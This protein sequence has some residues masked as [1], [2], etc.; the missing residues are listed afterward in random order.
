[1]TSI[2]RPNAPSLTPAIVSTIRRRKTGHR[3]IVPMA[4]SR[5]HPSGSASDWKNGVSHRVASW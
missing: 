2:P 4:V 3:V 5:N 1:V